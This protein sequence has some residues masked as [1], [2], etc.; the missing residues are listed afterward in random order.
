M[1]LD[2]HIPVLS[3]D[4][5]KERKK[6]V[7]KWKEKIISQAHASIVQ[8]L[9]WSISGE[10]KAYGREYRSHINPPSPASSHIRN[11]WYWGGGA[12]RNGLSSD[13]ERACQWSLLPC[14]FSLL[15]C[16]HSAACVKG[17][18]DSNIHT[19]THTYTQWK[20]ETLFA[21]RATETWKRLVMVQRGR[22]DTVKLP[23]LADGWITYGVPVRACGVA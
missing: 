20:R 15:W 21:L 17:E 14:A 13:A 22:G 19:N 1:L 8:Y 18:A 6:R 16:C 2:D 5:G 3:T 23:V 4:M 10:D 12:Q 9:R 7:K 11:D